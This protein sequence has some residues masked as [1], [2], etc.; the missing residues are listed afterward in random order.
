METLGSESPP[1]PAVCRMADSSRCVFEMLSPSRSLFVRL[2][3]GELGKRSGR[4]LVTYASFLRLRSMER[5]NTL[6]E[7]LC[8]QKGWKVRLRQRRVERGVSD[9][10]RGPLAKSC[11]QIPTWNSIPFLW[12]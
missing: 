1:F 6:S 5:S 3:Q 9:K 8:D 10:T 4:L 2:L 12:D 7:V 11:L